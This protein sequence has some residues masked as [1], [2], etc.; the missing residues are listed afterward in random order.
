VAKIVL[1]GA[2]FSVAGLREAHN[3]DALTDTHVWLE[4]R[5]GT[6]I[7][8]HHAVPSSGISSQLASRNWTDP[9]WGSQVILAGLYRAIGLRA[10]PVMQMALQLMVAI[11]AFLLAGGRR[12]RFWLPIVLSVCAQACLFTALARP[13]LQ[14]ALLLFVELWL[15]SASNAIRRLQLLSW[16]PVLMLLWANLDWHFV[17]GIAALFLFSL[18]EALGGIHQY[19]ESAADPFRMAG[20]AAVITAASFAASLLSPASYH[21][22]FTAWQRC[23]GAAKLGFMP[24]MKSLSFRSPEQFLLIVLAMLAFFAI[25][26]NQAREPF[27]LLLLTAS[28]C[29][30]IAAAC[31]SWAITVISVFILGD[32]LCA[33]EPEEELRHWYKPVFWA[34]TAVGLVVLAISI[35]FIPSRTEK[36][37]AVTQ[38]EFPVRASNFIRQNRLP[39]PIFN[40][41]EWGD[42]LT[43]YLPEYLVSI[44]SRYELYGEQGFASYHQVETGTALISEYSEFSSANTFLLSPESSLVRNP[45]R[46]PNPDEAFKAAF[47]GF[48]VVYRDDLAVVLSKQK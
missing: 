24:G 31:G 27:K 25:G 15:L 26:R 38:Q 35:L 44:D 13:L 21:S 28:V 42:F 20:R 8:L 10:I 14:D 7:L 2:L 5:L 23:V 19:R 16:M 40:Q 1:L 30:G 34:G 48:S 33:E 39:A 45:Q 3:L 9:N 47:P 32:A 36:L 46:Y 12:G 11:L 22:Y 4:L 37:L 17:L 18:G 6:W 29:L 43:W 41:L